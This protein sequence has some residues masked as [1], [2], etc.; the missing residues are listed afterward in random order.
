MLPEI[1]APL[2]HIFKQVTI[3]NFFQSLKEKVAI[4]ALQKFIPIFSPNNFNYIPP[5]ASEGSFKFL[6]HLR[7]SADGTIQ[8]LKITVNNKNK[9]VQILPGSQCQCANRFWFIHFSVANISKN[10]SACFFY[11]TPVNHIA[12][13][14]RLINCHNGAQPH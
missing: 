12:H 8:S 5:S 13:E 9:V 4:F 14:A 6:D 11:K 7:I 2:Y 10:F 3:D 1:C